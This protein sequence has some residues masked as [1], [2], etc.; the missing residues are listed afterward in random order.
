[1]LK[2]QTNL[3]VLIAI[4]IGIVIGILL[5]DAFT[6]KLERGV[7]YYQ[8]D[9]NKAK[10]FLINGEVK[11][12][13]SLPA[14]EVDLGKYKPP[15]HS[16]FS[17]NSQQMIY[18]KKTGEEP[19]ES[20]DENIVIARVITEPT[21]VNLK[22][23]KERKIDQLI[24]SSGVV[25]SPNDEKIAW[26]KEVPES[27]YGEIET[28]GKKREL[29]VSRAD[30][31]NSELLGEFDENVV[32]LRRWYSDY[33]YFQ[34]LWDAN[35]RSLGRISVKTGK[36][37]YL[38]PRYCEQYLENCKEIL[39]SLTGRKM[40]Y[41]IYS[42]EEKE[43]TELYL[44]DF[45]KR[46]FLEILTTDRISDRVWLNN[47]KEFLYTEQEMIKKE[48]MKE[49]IHLVDVK[50]KTDDVVYA[51]SYISQLVVGPNDRYLYFLEKEKDG[52]NFNLMKLNIKS[53]KAEVILTEDYNHILLKI[54]S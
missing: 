32:L 4:L 47:E 51:G 45:D 16:Y 9:G 5:W 43:I 12:I 37:E 23:G 25:F 26:L 28:S 48:G 44:G 30:G 35:I 17:N 34:G 21:L 8:I 54:G 20:L 42:N 39:F 38:V 11:E 19:L 27:T 33:I 10:L 14:R 2:K 24:D 29:W 3:F 41:E 50:S 1:M 46:E 15:R 22:T 18:F 31:E 40:I 52:E 7:F 6:P 36:I 13:V 53:G 49:S